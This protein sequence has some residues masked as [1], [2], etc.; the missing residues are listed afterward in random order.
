M[1][2]PDNQ[3]SMDSV[4]AYLDETDRLRWSRP[5][6][7]VLWM[8]AGYKSAEEMQKHLPLLGGR[9]SVKDI[10]EM[11]KFLRDGKKV[12]PRH[13]YENLGRSA[14]RATNLFKCRKCDQKI[15]IPHV[16]VSG[17]VRGEAKR[18]RKRHIHLVKN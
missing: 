6:L 14:N 4:N 17:L 13:E 11:V 10:Q 16:I 3:I 2:Y 12:C 7:M 5:E 15:A 18:L 9:R 1:V 8:F